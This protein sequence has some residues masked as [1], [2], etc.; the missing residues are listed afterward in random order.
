MSEFWSEVTRQLSPYIPGEQP[1]VAGLIKLNT[2][3]H[4]MPPSDL[5][6]QAI[7]AVSSDGLRR[8]PDPESRQLRQAI[9][10]AENL[11][12]EQVFVG[13]GSDEVLAHVFQALLT[14]SDQVSMPAITYSFYEVWARLYGINCR[15]VA[16]T[17]AFELDIEGLVSGPGPI[18]IAN[19]NA[20]TGIALG[21]ESIRRL[22]DSNCHRLVV[23][24]EAYFGF[25]AA[26]AA[27]LIASYPNLLVTR[28]LSKSH[29]LAGLR[30]GYALGSP[31]LI[32]GLVRVKDSFNSYPIDSVAQA[33]GAAAVSD[34]EWLASA[35]NT[36]VASREWLSG[37]LLTLGFDVCP[38]QANFLF[39]KHPR[40]SGKA[41]FEILRT[42]NILVRRWNRPIIEDHLRITIGTQEHCEILADCLQAALEKQR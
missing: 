34:R 40:I 8:Y 29:A 38:S 33:A 6:L 31:D 3:E 16:L 7:S 23:I 12:P 15:E 41:L 2:N 22:L 42:E 32:E 30:V 10:A 11:E 27:T 28:S 1:R 24:D 26:T 13:N 25:G 4:P 5:A 14:R 18:L 36:V 19:P 39:V 21:L 20:P 17:A 9:A 37:R 35:S